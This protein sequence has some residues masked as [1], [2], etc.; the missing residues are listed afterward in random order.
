M[1][2]LDKC[3][4]PYIC[5]YNRIIYISHALLIKKGDN[6]CI[7]TYSVAEFGEMLPDSISND[8]VL[9]SY[10]YENEW[11]YLYVGNNTSFQQDAKEANSR[12]KLLIWL[13]END[14]VNVEDLN[15]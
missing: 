6:N 13:I 10:R 2:I 14:Y 5:I 1:H 4:F 7:N 9:D 8:D 3:T 11:C 15:K 12:A